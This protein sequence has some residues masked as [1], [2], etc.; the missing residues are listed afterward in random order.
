MLAP[1]KSNFRAELYIP[2]KEVFGADAK[3]VIVFKGTDPNCLEDC[4]ADY[5]QARGKTSSYYKQAIKLGQRLNDFMGGQFESAGH[6]LGGG[7]ASAVGTVTGC[8]T[9][10]F[11]PAG[12]H[13]NT[14]ALYNKNVTTDSANVSA[15][16]VE[17]EVVNS[18]Q[19]AARR[20]N[21]GKDSVYWKPSRTP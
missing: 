19:D 2:D 20:P 11:N 10:V 7:M 15:F 21:R 17:G 18:S 8:R 12:L 9:T 13:P 1:P 6:S 16:V 14:V 3:P 5:A 4:Q